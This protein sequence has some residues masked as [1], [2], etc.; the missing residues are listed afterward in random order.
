MKKPTQHHSLTALRAVVLAAA[1]AIVSTGQAQV[2][3]QQVTNGLVDFYPLDYLNPGGGSVLTTPD[4]IGGRDLILANMGASNIVASTHS[5]GAVTNCFNMPQTGNVATLLYYASTGQDPLTGAG[6]FLPFCN[7]RNAT[8][9]FWVKANGLTSQADKRFF[10]EADNLNTTGDPLFLIGCSSGTADTSAHWLFRHSSSGP[11]AGTTARLDGSYQAPAPGYYWTQGNELTGQPVLDNTWH[12]FSMTIDSNGSVN[13]YVDGVLDLGGTNVAHVDAY[14]NPSC[15]SVMPVTNYYYTTN[16]YPPAGV[17]NPPPDGYVRWVFNGIVQHGSTVFG[18]F[19]RGGVSFGIPCQIDDIAFWNRVLSQQELE[20]VRTNG[21]PDI[22]PDPYI[23]RLASF[24]ADFGEVAQHDYVTLNWIA[25]GQGVTINISGVGDVTAAGLAGSTNVQLDANQTYNFTITVHQPLGGYTD[26]TKSVS[27]KTFPGVSS[28]WHLV[29]RFDGLAD[30][31]AGVN[32]N[33]WVSA[34]SSYQGNFDR[35][36]VVTFT[37]GGGANKVLTPRTGYVPNT[38]SP[39]GYDSRGAVSYAGL[40]SLTLSPGHTNTLFF[41]FSLHDPYDYAYVPAYSGLDCFIGLTDFNFWAGAFGGTAGT[42]A[43]MGPYINI[44][45]SDASGSYLEVPFDLL[46]YDYSGSAITNT[47]SYLGGNPAG[48]ETNVNYLVWMNVENYNTQ[49]HDNGDGTTNTINMPVYSVYLQKQ[50]DPN[51]TL[52]FSGFHGDRDFVG[53]VSGA[54]VATP[55]LD[56]VFCDIGTES[57]AASTAGAY[58]ETNMITVDDIYLSKNGA[59]ATIPRLFDLTSVVRGPSGVTLT[60]DSL[61]SMW[62]VNTYAVQRK[63]SLN[64]PSWT[65]VASG[66]PSGG[67]TTSYTDTTVGASEKAFYRIVW[68]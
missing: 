49:A 29:E 13:V 66:I 1:A 16:I 18:G 36:N 59:N 65:T 58:F 46:A 40:G 24:T 7:Q 28:A 30:T 50:G 33:N 14:G 39:T 60:W 3:F 17:S 62:Q 45:R 43:F 35:W 9:N 44:V 11:I 32:V 6:D 54:N 53:L 56:K 57:V 27:V 42:A 19:K 55:Y 2:T 51:R 15:L 63:L 31:T 25:S 26:Q 41:R 34:L 68:P 10:G 47:Y 67:T 37:N 52:L 12:M 8:M 48:L 23:P 21:L 5:G 38:A 22:V 4:L 64:D 61:G 20:F